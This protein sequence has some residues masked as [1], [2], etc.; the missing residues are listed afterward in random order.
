MNSDVFLSLFEQMKANLKTR[1]ERAGDKVE[2]V[3]AHCDIQKP[4]ELGNQAFQRL[5]NGIDHP[6]MQNR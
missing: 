5:G 3:Q 1:A 2:G 6:R 4:R